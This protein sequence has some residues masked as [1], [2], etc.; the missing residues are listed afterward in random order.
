MAEAKTKII[1]A[2]QGK[3]A[4]FSHIAAMKLFG[5][6][7][8]LI[9]CDTFGD[10][11]SALSRGGAHA[12]VVPIENSTY[13]SIYQNYDNISKNESSLIGEIILK[14]N[15]HLIAHPGKNVPDIK[16]VYSHPVGLG[17]IQ[18][19]IQNHPNIEFIEHDDTAGAVKMVKKKKLQSAGACASRFAAEYYGM[20]VIA[21]NIHENPKNYTRFFVVTRPEMRKE[22]S[23]YMTNKEKQKRKTTIQFQLGEE[24]GSLYKALGCFAKRGL[25]LTKIES[26]PVLNTDWEYRFYLDVLANAN[27]PKFMKAIQELVSYT[28]HLKILGSYVR[29]EYLET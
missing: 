11:F 16:R 18:A 24:A 28:K 5:R 20:E 17:Q 14:I 3:V 19:F 29:G 23:Q 8:S 25:A 6:D 12:A 27:N 10:V 1:I 13:G 21:E 7:I 2:I 22:V 4:S 9:E 26:R 15:F